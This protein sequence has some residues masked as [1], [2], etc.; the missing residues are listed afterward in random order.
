[1]KI[2]VDGVNL[3]E[4]TEIQKN[5]ICDNLSLDIFD[6]DMKRRLQWV[7]MHKYEE[8][9]KALKAEWDQKLINN[10]VDS[11]PTNPDKY[12]ELVFSQPNY[13]CRKTRDEEAAKLGV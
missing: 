4:I 1:M 5:V 2:S 8:C 9:F 6:E 10:G 12:A 11:V 7:I 3:F 13:K